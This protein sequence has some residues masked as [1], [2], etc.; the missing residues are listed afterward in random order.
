MVAARCPTALLN[1]QTGKLVDKARVYTAFRESCCDAGAEDAW[2]NLHRGAKEQLTQEQVAKRLAYG[3]HMQ[4]LGHTAAYYHKKLVWTDLC[5]SIL[6]R[7]VKRTQEQA[8]ARKGG[9][10]WMSKSQRATNVNLK[11]SK[12]ALRQATWETVRMWWAPILARGKLHIE[13]LGGKEFPGETEEGAAQ[14]VKKVK[15]GLNIRFQSGDAPSTVYVDRGKGFY[16]IANAKIT[17]GFKEALRECG[18]HAFW[19]DDASAQPGQLQ[20]L[21]LHETAVRW[22]RFHERR[23]LPKRPWEETEE[24]FVARLKGI[25]A[26]CNKEYDVEGLTRGFPKRIKALVE[27]AGERIPW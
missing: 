15:T 20:E 16:H 24:Q 22:I 17:S 13:F 12:Q 21:M 27:K 14:L 8:L 18:L 9:K 19:G 11:K 25:A 5:N 26:T 7:S 10:T 6:P 2:D 1:P 4:A 23:T 3:L